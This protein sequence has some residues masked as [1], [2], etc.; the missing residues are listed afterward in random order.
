MTNFIV[1]EEYYSVEQC[2]ANRDT[3]YIFGDN[4][5]RI[6]SGGQAIIRSE[7]NVFGLPT[8]IFPLNSPQSYLHDYDQESYLYVTKFY[9]N[10]F[11]KLDKLST[12]YKK[13]VFPAAGLGTGLSRMPEHAPKLLKYID[14]R[15]SILIGED[16]AK[17]RNNLHL[18]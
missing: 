3:L 10:V 13:V 17:Y 18:A 14:F 1:Q 7:R 4:L 15:V 5:I 9:C 12:G 2:R 8:K 6:G 11:M 16:Y